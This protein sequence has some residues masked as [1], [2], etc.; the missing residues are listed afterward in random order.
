MVKDNIKDIN[1]II[2]I[3]KI[4]KKSWSFSDS[5]W[6]NP[7]VSFLVRTWFV[8]GELV[9]NC[10]A[11]FDSRFS[12]WHH[13][14]KTERNEGDGEGKPGFA[15]KFSCA[16][17]A[18]AKKTVSKHWASHLIGILC[19]GCLLVYHFKNVSSMFLSKIGFHIAPRL[20]V[21]HTWGVLI[22]HCFFHIQHTWLEGFPLGIGC[23]TSMAI[24][25]RIRSSWA[26][27][28]QT[29]RSRSKSGRMERAC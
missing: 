3:F 9:Q 27:Q 26:L 8:V 12:D 4:T 28:Q 22:A 10:L 1:S 23:L 19:S 11:N 20:P 29:E 5:Q 7:Y 14:V 2:G 16:R 24:L 15:A 6:Q 25:D 13:A 18:Y 21:S 17:Q